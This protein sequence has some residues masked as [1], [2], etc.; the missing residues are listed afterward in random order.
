MAEAHAGPANGQQEQ[1]QQGETQQREEPQQQGEKQQRQERGDVMQR[2]M[3]EWMTAWNRLDPQQREVLLIAG[4]RVVE[5]VEG[6]TPEQKA[7]VIRGLDALAVDP[8][9]DYQELPEQRREAV[10]DAI[11]QL[12]GAYLDLT[13]DQKTRFL[14]ELAGSL[15]DL[16]QHDAQ[17]QPQQPQQ[18]PMQ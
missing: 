10:Q 9:I 14:T 17:Q 7:S 12:R 13:A 2:D 1:R 16:Q 11:S 15:G 18:Q 4:R 3:K 5:E 6:L 8:T